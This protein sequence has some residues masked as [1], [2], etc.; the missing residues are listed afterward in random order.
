ME[1]PI[2]KDNLVDFG[3][4]KSQREEEEPLQVRST[5]WKN[6]CRHKRR[7]VSPD[8]RKVYCRDC[9]AELDPIT[10]LKEIGQEF[11]GWKA[12]QTRKEMERL[13]AL[14][15]QIESKAKKEMMSTTEIEEMQKDPM[16]WRAKHQCMDSP[17][18]L[19]VDRDMIRCFCGSS[20][21]RHVYPDS[22]RKVREAHERAAR[23]AGFELKEWRPEKT[24]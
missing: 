12:V 20:Y 24:G 9:E 15:R 22:A 1:I 14:E 21:N 7:D 13:R 18:R 17:E 10:V 23:K 5:N 4:L 16:A 3:L 19:V 11:S 2:P 8:D 6:V